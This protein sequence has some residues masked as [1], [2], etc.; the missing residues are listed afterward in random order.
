MNIIRMI[1]M[2]AATLS[3]L[4]MVAIPVK[5]RVNSLPDVKAFAICA[6]TP[7]VFP[8]S[9]GPIYDDSMACLS[10]FPT[11][12]VTLSFTPVSPSFKPATPSSSESEFS[13]ILSFSL[14]ALSHTLSAP[15][16]LVIY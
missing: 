9:I 6:K 8:T 15:N 12:S 14:L 3:D 16:P 5:I 2:T 11:T 7:W 13:V 4:N 1:S 10:I